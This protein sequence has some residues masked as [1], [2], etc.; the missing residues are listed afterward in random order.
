MARRRRTRSPLAPLTYAQL[1]RL[2]DSQTN[3]AQAPERR[4]IAAE[5]KRQSKLAEQQQATLYESGLATSRLLREAA[6][7]SEEAY[8]R[9]AETMGSLSH[10]TGGQLEEDITRSFGVNRP[11]INPGLARRVSEQLGG[12]IPA[13]HLLTLGAGART[14]GE[15]TAAIS[16]KATSETIESAVRKALEGDAELGQ[17]LIDLAAKRP[18][19]RAQVL[20]ALQK[21]EMD[22]RAQSLYERQFGLKEEEF[23]FDQET[24]K[25][26]F[27]IELAKLERAGHEVDASASKDVGY[28]VD[29]Y[30]DPILRNGKRIPTKAPTSSR[31]K[32]VADARELRGEPVEA[33]TLV[34]GPGGGRPPQ[35]KYLT[36]PG[37]KGFPDGTTNS[38]AKAKYD[39]AYTFV[40][41]LNYLM[42]LYPGMKRAAARAALRAAGWIPDG[43][44]PKTKSTRNR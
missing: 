14:H 34:Q 37:A 12:N 20:A 18:E 22:K 33:P 40:E 44:R 27:E 28:F 1:Q 29:Q 19:V 39:S 13:E 21:F 10:A 41:A 38:A 11:T 7:R 5:R 3:A 31:N 42:E 24:Q 35:G 30:G 4:A 6:P 43:K 26:K 2:A 32:A 36:R 9:A 8:R 17:K 25:T 16:M 23:A 15:Q